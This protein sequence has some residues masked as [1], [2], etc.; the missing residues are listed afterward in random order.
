M[1]WVSSARSTPRR[2]DRRGTPAGRRRRLAC[3]AGAGRSRDAR[4][5]C[6][7]PRALAQQV[8]ADRDD[9]EDADEQVGQLRRQPAGS[10]PRSTVCTSS[11]PSTV[12]STEPRPP[13]IEVPPMTTAAITASSLPVPTFWPRVEVPWAMTKQAASPTSSPVS[14]VGQQHPALHLHPGQPGGVRRRR[15]WRRSAGRRRCAAGT[16]R[17]A[18]RCTS[19]IRNACGTPS[20]R[21]AAPRPKN[22]ERLR[23]VVDGAASRRSAGRG[24]GRCS[25]CRT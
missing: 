16:T 5:S 10:P 9:D 17:R 18:R 15:R 13:M 14:D 1:R 20:V 23:D 19:V 11:A 12:P 22:V 25:R 21:P 24:T 7:P 3:G 6:R 4:C 2:A 8:G